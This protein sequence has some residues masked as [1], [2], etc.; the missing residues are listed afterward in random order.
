MRIRNS[1]CGKSGLDSAI[2]T[3]KNNG[4]T[5]NKRNKSKGL[6]IGGHHEKTIKGKNIN[7]GDYNRCNT[8]FCYCSLFFRFKFGKDNANRVGLCIPGGSKGW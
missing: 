8:C 6:R 7:K 2:A 4:S 1:I 5:V 3:E